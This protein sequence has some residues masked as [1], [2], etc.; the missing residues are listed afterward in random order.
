MYESVHRPQGKRRERT[1]TLPLLLC[2]VVIG[3]VI[4]LFVWAGRYQFRYR[5]FTLELAEVTTGARDSGSYTVTVDGEEIPVD[6]ETLSSLFYSISQ[7]GSGRIGDAP[8]TEPKIKV[9]YGGGITLEIW[10]VPLENPGND[11]TEGPLFRYT[12]RDGRPYSYD[13]DQIRPETLLR[14]FR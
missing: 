11:W 3:A 10:I 2:A 12:G 6:G 7:A 13:T 9:D 8:E 4:L 14:L 1:L 5:E